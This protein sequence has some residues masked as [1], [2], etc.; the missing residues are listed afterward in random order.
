MNYNK[1]IVHYGFW[2]LTR[3]IFELVL[4]KCYFKKARLIRRP[5]DI[6]GKRLINFGE[7]LTTGRYC[8]LEAYGE[9]KNG[10]KKLKFGNNVQINDN[11]HIVASESVVIGNNVLMASNIFISDTS[12][13]QYGV[14][15]ST[16]P[17]TIPIERKK[18]TKK[19]VIGDNVWI[20]ENVIILPGV[21]IEDGSIIG[22]GSV[23]TKN[24][25]KNSIV[26]GNPAKV[27]KMFNDKTEKWEKIY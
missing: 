19:V 16:N 25:Q 4:T 3:L 7:G 15:I 24:I 5:F 21:E 23:V 1:I 12:H 2:G 6:R 10:L 11:V 17:K 20:G 18:Y 9:T 13:G 14:E 27:T 8:R 22:A 26:L